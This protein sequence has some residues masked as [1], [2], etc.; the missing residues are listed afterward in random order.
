M[1]AVLDF[2]HPRGEYA[3]LL[4]VAALLAGAVTASAALLGIDRRR[5]GSLWWYGGVAFVVAGR[6][7]FLARESPR[8]LL[9][10]LVAIRLQGGIV[11]L[12][13]V[14]GVAGVAAA[15]AWLARHEAPARRVPAFG[16]AALGLT[17]AAAGYD[18][19]CI[20]RDAC[21]GHVAPAPLGI[22][23]PG[24]T[25]ARLATPL[26]EAALLLIAGG[27]LLATAPPV[28][29]AI[30]LGGIAALLHA[31]LAPASVAGAAA[32]GIEDA[33]FAVVGAVLVAAAIAIA[34]AARHRA[35]DAPG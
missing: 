35:P 9:D 34:V 30:A 1:S 29:G 17:I 4:I 15:G 31:A 20:A 2:V 6:V 27:A 32:L 13:G 19:A 26:I 33:A 14:A 18:V 7:A 25:Q 8:S 24:L 22:V 10:P 11:P 3:S 16:A 5:L 28:T 21:A 12:A 23:M